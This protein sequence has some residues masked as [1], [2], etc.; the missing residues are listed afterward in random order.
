MQLRSRRRTKLGHWGFGSHDVKETA[1]DENEVVI[2]N[3]G[4]LNGCSAGESVVVC[5]GVYS[6]DSMVRAS[7]V[8][9]MGLGLGGQLW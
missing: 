8:T 4:V 2:G 5:L 6:S 7:G 9:I 1:A 3:N